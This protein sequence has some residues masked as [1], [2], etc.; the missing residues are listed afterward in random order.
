MGASAGLSPERFKTTNR[1]WLWFQAGARLLL[2]NVGH[3]MKSRSQRSL[4]V[5]LRSEPSMMHC[6]YRTDSRNDQ[7]EV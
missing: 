5:E 7:S 1:Q 4:L 3:L 6:V 2:M